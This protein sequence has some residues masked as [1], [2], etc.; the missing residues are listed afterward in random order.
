[1]KALRV[2]AY[3][4]PIGSV[5]IVCGLVALTGSPRTMNTFGLVFCGVLL[6]AVTVFAAWQH[7]RL[8]TC[9]EPPAGVVM[10]SRLELAWRVL[11]GALPAGIIVYSAATPTGG[12]WIAGVALGAFMLSAAVRAAHIERRHGGRLVRV[13]SRFFLAH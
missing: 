4:G 7:S 10:G 1:V 11:L 8:G 13:D 12:S 5:W 6:G 9:D 3:D 2:I